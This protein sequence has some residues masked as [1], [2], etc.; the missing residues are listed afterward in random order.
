MKIFPKL[1]VG[2]FADTAEKLLTQRIWKNEDSK[3][4]FQKSL[5]LLLGLYYIAYQ[6]EY[7]SDNFSPNKWWLYDLSDEENILKIKSLS[8]FKVILKKLFD[9][10]SKET[11]CVMSAIL[12]ISISL[13]E[14]NLIEKRL[15]LYAFNNLYPS[16]GLNIYKSVYNDTASLIIIKGLNELSSNS[17][18]LAIY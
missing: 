17:I 1:S 16:Q 11:G 7:S 10:N 12:P 14:K 6:K 5:S 9:E 2:I 13:Y 8:N 4:E 15:E 3:N 18:D